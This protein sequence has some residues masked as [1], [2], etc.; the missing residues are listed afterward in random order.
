MQELFIEKIFFLSESIILVLTRSLEIRI[1]YTEKLIH[2]PYNPDNKDIKKKS[3][4][5]EPQ[6]DDGLMINNLN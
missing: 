1:F 6:V 3:A 4:A 2:G 5:Q